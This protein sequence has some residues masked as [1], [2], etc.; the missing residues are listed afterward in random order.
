M[1]DLIEE[2]ISLKDKCYYKTGGFAKWYAEPKTVSQLNAILVW[3]KRGNVPFEIIGCGANLL[4]SDFGYNGL[5][6]SCSSLEQFIKIKEKNIIYCGAGVRLDKFTE[7]AVN[8][9]FSGAENLSG[10]PGSIGGAVIMNAGAFGTEI[11][12][13]A[14]KIYAVDFEG[15]GRAFSSDE[16]L[17]GYRSSKGLKG[18]IVT[19]GEFSLQKGHI[20]SLKTL[21]SDILQRRRDKQPLDKPSCGSVFKRPIKGYAGQLI[22]DCGLKGLRHGGA[23]ISEKHA[24]FI[25]NDSNATSADIKWLIDEAIRRVKDKFGIILEPEVR[26]IGF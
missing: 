5:I 15:N 18:Y 22:E 14:T 21:R 24:N 16:V 25:L 1:I 9:G 11:K 17:F 26:L 2:N 13:I 8:N 3:A 10:I 20:D 23:V 19:G 6:I 7:F 4:I 12:D